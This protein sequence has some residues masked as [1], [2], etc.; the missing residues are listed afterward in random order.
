MRPFVFALLALAP[1]AAAACPPGDP[2]LA[3]RYELQGVMEVG[4][5]IELLADGRFSYGLAY[6]ALDESATGCWSRKGATVT[7]NVGK[8]EA[9][10]EDP[11]KFSRLELKIVAHGALLRVFD[12]KHSGRYVRY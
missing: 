8:F 12:E 11:M 5:E 3:A 10:M 2:K 6:G 1:T 9:G 7:L 4:S